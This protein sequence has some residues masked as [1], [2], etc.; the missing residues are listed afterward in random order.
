MGLYVYII[1][2]ESHQTSNIVISFYI[3]QK[4]WTS[5]HVDIYHQHYVLV[6][7]HWSPVGERLHFFQI[8]IFSLY[9]KSSSQHLDVKLWEVVRYSTW[10]SKLDLGLNPKP[11]STSRLYDFEKISKPLQASVSPFV[12]WG[13]LHFPFDY[14]NNSKNN[15]PL[16][17]RL[18]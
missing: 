2:T 14:L 11:L 13:Q 16:G 10:D 3:Q 4:L 5:L 15:E 9:K 17:G 18:V 8:I 1:S 6:L 12:K 7:A